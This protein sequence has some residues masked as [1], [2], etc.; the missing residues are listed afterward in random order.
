MWLLPTGHQAL[1]A[2]SIATHASLGDTSAP[3]P[4]LAPEGVDVVVSH[5]DEALAGGLLAAALLLPGPRRLLY[6]ATL[7]RFRSQE[8]VFRSAELKAAQLG[9]KLEVQVG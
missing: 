4:P 6:R 8:A 2:A 5:K 3:I 9:E 7:G 1:Q